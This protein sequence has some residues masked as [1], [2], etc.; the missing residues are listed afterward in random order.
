[1]RDSTRPRSTVGAAAATALA[2]ALAGCATGAAGTPADSEQIAERSRALGI[3]PDLVFTTDVGGYE[4][5]VQSVA[6]NGAEGMSAV[7]LDSAGGMLTLRTEYGG[8]SDE[9]CASGPVEGAYE[10]A[11]TCLLEETGLWLRSA[12]DAH[13][14]VAT[15]DHVLIRVASAAAPIERLREAV[16]AAHVPSPAE[17][18]LLFLDAPVDP[19]GPP[20]ERGDLPENG[21]G[22]PIDPS[23]PGG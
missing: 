4:L 10:A 18:D 5:Q 14:Y 16:D 19:T 9:E 6:P 3:A 1:M 11:V 22:A 20:V 21:D 7:W 23:G 12:G 2:F 15:R 8:F 13:E 17:L